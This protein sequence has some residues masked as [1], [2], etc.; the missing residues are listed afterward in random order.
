M[1][2]DPM[3]TYSRA[4]QE[5]RSTEERAKY[6]VTMIVSAANKLEYRWKDVEVQNVGDIQ[7]PPG[8]TSKILGSE[9]PDGKELRRRS[10]PTTTP[11][12]LRR[13]RMRGFRK[14]RKP[15]PLDYRGDTTKDQCP[16]TSNN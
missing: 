2:D 16:S 7:F 3:T 9:L 15:G 11:S 12:P 13:W 4:I 14:N 10:P 5:V 8:Q 6:L 1:S